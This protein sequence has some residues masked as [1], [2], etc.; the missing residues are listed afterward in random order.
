[1]HH[2]NTLIDSRNI[3]T[4]F[5]RDKIVFSATTE[6][7]ELEVTLVVAG[8]Y[9]SSLSDQEYG[10]PTIG[11]RFKGSKIRYCVIYAGENL[12]CVER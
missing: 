6:T 4:L 9:L 5:L 3:S 7:F 10:G 8:P 12:R 2:T 1:M 11:I